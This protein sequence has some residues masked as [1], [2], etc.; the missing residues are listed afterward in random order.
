LTSKK[1]NLPPIAMPPSTR[2]PDRERI[3]R[4]SLPPAPPESRVSLPPRL[5]GVVVNTTESTRGSVDVLAGTAQAVARLE[6]EEVLRQ[7]FAI[8]VQSLGFISLVLGFV[9]SILVYQAGLQALR[10]VPD[11]S[12][13]GSAY[14][15]LLVKDLAASITGL[16]LATRVGAGIAA[17]I[18]SMKVTDQLDALRLCNTD[19]VDYLVAPRVVASVL[20]TPLLTLFGGTAAVLTGATTGYWAFGINPT[21]FLDP[22][23]IDA[24]DVIVGF[25]KSVC[26]GLA[27]PL[28][29][30]HAG[31]Y[32][33]GGSE[34]VGNATTRAVVGSSLAVIIMG[35]LI[36]AVAE[37][38]FG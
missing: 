6:P 2:R 18:G 20:A 36:G 22:R 23:H 35:F 31:L 5:P 11:T 10:I 25:L 34:G 30:A 19:P 26:F 27:I 21:I 12:T 38:L 8:G 4:I 28:V 33:Q 13:V 37:V 32:T 14:L 3:S 9:G 29:S 15:E 16:M 7:F 1:P 24:V 17:E